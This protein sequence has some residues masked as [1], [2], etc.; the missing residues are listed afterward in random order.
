VIEI[1]VDRNRLEGGVNLVGEGSTRF[2]AE[3]GARVL[4]RRPPRPDLAA[5]PE[6][7]TTR[8]SGPR[9][10]RPAAHLGRLRVRRDAITRRLR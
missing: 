6:L 8:A 1:T 3:E 5:D 2:G 10:S 4:A 7:A 9:C